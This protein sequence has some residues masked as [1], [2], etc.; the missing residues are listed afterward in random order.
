MANYVTVDGPP[1]QLWLPRMI[2]F[3]ASGSPVENQ[4][5]VEINRDWRLLQ[6]LTLATD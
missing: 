6:C 2:R 1:D 5:M 3:A 4:L